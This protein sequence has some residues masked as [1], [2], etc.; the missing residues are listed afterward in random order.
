MAFARIAAQ[1][2]PCVSLAKATADETE[3]QPG[4]EDV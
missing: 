3:H 4:L 2:L 1:G